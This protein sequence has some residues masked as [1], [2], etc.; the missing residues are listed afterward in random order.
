MHKATETAF[1]R[2]LLRGSIDLM[3]LSVLAEAPLY[4]YLIQKRLREASGNLVR[5]QAGT[6]YPL[7]YRLEAAGAVTSRR[8]TVGG[9]ERKWYTLTDSGRRMLRHQAGQWQQYVEC[10]RKLLHPALANMPSPA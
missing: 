4:G 1:E 2:D 3:V 7:M 8:E 9:R 10:I 5:I 6:L